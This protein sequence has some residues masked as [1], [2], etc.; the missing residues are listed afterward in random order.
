MTPTEK[1]LWKGAPLL[2]KTKDG[3]GLL[4]GKKTYEFSRF[5][6]LEKVQPLTR[7]VL[8]MAIKQAHPDNH[9]LVMA[10][11]ATTLSHA[12]RQQARKKRQ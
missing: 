8:E 5:G 1:M 7:I 11:K 12:I 2:F 3:V 4:V 10:A 6:D 9:V